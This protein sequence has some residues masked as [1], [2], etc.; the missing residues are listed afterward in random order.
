MDLLKKEVLALAEEELGI[1]E[2]EEDRDGDT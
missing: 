2:E 1:T